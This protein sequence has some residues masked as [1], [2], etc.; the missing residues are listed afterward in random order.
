METP[1]PVLKKLKL[2]LSRQ[3]LGATDLKLGMHTQFDSLTH[4]LGPTRPHLFFL[5]RKDKKLNDEKWYF[6][7]TLGPRKLN[8]LTHIYLEPALFVDCHTPSCVHVGGK[9][10]QG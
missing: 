3:A 4:R 6:K 5:V 7:K 8:P 10:S 9:K 2:Y 1:F